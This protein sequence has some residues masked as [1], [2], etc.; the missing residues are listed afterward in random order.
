MHKVGLN[1]QEEINFDKMI[2]AIEKNCKECG[3]F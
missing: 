2:S 1:H 3:D